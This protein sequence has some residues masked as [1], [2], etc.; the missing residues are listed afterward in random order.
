MNFLDFQRPQRY[1][2]NELNA[3]KKNH[4]GKISF[5]LCYPDLYE[6]GM[7][8]LGL[9]II[10]GLL[11]SFPDIVCE[12]SFLPGPDLIDYLKTTQKPLFSL[13]TKTPLSQFDL[14]G[15]NF[16]YELNFLNFLTMLEAGGIPLEAEKRKKN[17]IIGGGIAN[18]QPL[19]SFVDAFCLGE[20]EAVCADL[21]HALRGHKN[22]KSRLQA[23]SRAEGFYVPSFYNFYF[24]GK[25]YEFEK[26]YPKARLPLKR[27]KVKN[28]NESFFPLKW[29]TPHTKLIQDR[30][31]LEIARGCP[32][33]CNFCQAKN[34]YQPYREKSAGHI[35]KTIKEVYKNSGYESFSLLSLSSSN[36][37]S[38]ELLLEKIIPF[39]Q[40]NKILLSL[41]SLKIGDSMVTIY[42][43]L[44]SF[45]KTP[46]TVAVE[47]GTD[48]LRKKLNKN[49]EVEKLFA[50]AETL[51][52]LGLEQIKVYFMYGFPQEKKEDLI[53]IGNFIRKLKE[54][55]RLKINASIN[56]FIPKPCSRWENIPFCQ[57]E[58][59]KAKKSIILNNIPFSKKIKIT[60]SQLDKSLI[61]VILSRADADIGPVL[62]NIQK[63]WHKLT[64]ENKLF[65]WEIWKEEFRKEKIDWQRYTKAETLNFPWSFIE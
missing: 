10:Y 32:N 50:W 28:L 64:K 8:N 6:I 33:N 42:K 65:S 56:L 9:R 21:I 58:D 37:S 43:K 3:V 55:T 41:P 13:E 63:K 22:K 46:L 45:Q 4:S 40:E 7:D 48:N 38:I 27:A 24:S 16:S 14:I 30:V 51:P 29:L 12:R 35:E 59:A 18:P 20:F 60:T 2:G 57:I 36:Y 23:L 11:N 1:L 49:I 34:I 31:P 62:L 54:K 53:A 61:E 15:F 19:A 52:K 39:V 17:I 5:C 47:A 44:L 25:K 26:K